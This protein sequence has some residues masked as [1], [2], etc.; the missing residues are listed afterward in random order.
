M[1]RLFL[2]GF[3]LLNWNLIL[4]QEFQ[5]GTGGERIGKAGTVVNAGFGNHTND[6]SVAIINGTPAGTGPCALINDKSLT[7]WCVTG[8]VSFRRYR[9]EESQREAGKRDR[10]PVWIIEKCTQRCGANM[11][12]YDF[13][14]KEVLASLTCHNIYVLPVLAFVKS[15]PSNLSSL[16]SLCPRC[17][18]LEDRWHARV[19][20]GLNGIPTGKNDVTSSY[21]ITLTIDK[22]PRRH[23]LLD[24]SVITSADN[25]DNGLQDGLYCFDGHAFRLIGKSG[26]CK[27]NNKGAGEKIGSHHVKLLSDYVTK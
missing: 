15:G 7:K 9:K 5:N 10:R 1:Y 23:N 22:K 27:E 24:S 4:A 25:G 6:V 21:K 13:V 3:L 20:R 11:L 12:V 17:I 18:R 14:S 2:T 8:D 26:H 16:R 19:I